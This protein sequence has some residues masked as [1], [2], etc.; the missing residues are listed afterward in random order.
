MSLARWKLTLWQM[1]SLAGLP[2]KYA[3]QVSIY[4]ASYSCCYLGNCFAG[5]AGAWWVD[6]VMEVVYER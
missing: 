5:T 6:V 1:L 2:T 4:Q 3:I